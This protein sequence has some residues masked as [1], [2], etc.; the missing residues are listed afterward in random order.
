MKTEFNSKDNVAVAILAIT[1]FAIV[2]AMLASNHAPANPAET[3]AV[4]KPVVI[5]DST[6]R[7]QVLKMESIVVTAS[8]KGVQL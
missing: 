3:V 1:L 8:R 7:P 4:Q 6:Q 2:G 5:V